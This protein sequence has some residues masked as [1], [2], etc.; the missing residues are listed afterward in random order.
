M[1]LT[2]SILCTFYQV[3]KIGNLAYL[4]NKIIFLK[5]EKQKNIRLLEKKEFEIYYL[6]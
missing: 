1:K 2:W 5:K 3:K 4:A 6:I